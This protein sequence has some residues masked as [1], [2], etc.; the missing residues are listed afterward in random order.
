MGPPLRLLLSEESRSGP[1]INL[2]ETVVQVLGEVGRA[3]TSPSY[4]WLV[5]GGPP[6]HPAVLFHYAPIRSGKVAEELVGDFQGYL[7]SKRKGRP[8]FP[9]SPKLAIEGDSQLS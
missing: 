1:I 7:Q 5:R 4:M 6:E 8:T 2:D 9:A 3:N